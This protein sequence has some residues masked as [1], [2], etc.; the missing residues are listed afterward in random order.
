[1]G[2]TNIRVQNEALFYDKRFGA[3]SA[4]NDRV[5]IVLI[6]ARTSS[7]IEHEKPLGLQADAYLIWQAGD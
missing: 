2:K 3:Q 4:S 7:Q 1:M 5:L 6:L